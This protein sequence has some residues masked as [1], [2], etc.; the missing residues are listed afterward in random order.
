MNNNTRYTRRRFIVATSA[1]GLGLSIGV[2]PACSQ[3]KPSSTTVDS[4]E[5]KESVAPILSTAQHDTILDEVNAWVHI[6]SDDT[7][8]VRIARSEMGQGTITG[9][10][11]LVAEELECDW[12]KVSFEFPTPGQSVARERVWGDFSTG[13]SNGLRGSQQYMREGGAAARLMLLQAAANRWNVPVSECRARDSVIMHEPSGNKLRFGQ[14]AAEAA[15]LEPPAEVTLKDPTDW[16]TAGASKLRLDTRDKVTGKLKYAA[17]TQLPG[18]LY[19][20]IQDCPVLGGK[21]KSFD[22]SSVAD[23][24]G[25]RNVVEVKTESGTHGVA[26]IADTWWQAHSALQK[27]PVEWDYG[28]NRDF[29]DAK[30]QALL[31]SGLDAD[32]AFVGHAGGNIQTAFDDASQMVEAVYQY[33]A[34]NH[35]PMEPMNAT[36]RWTESHCEVWCP[37]QNGESA[38][39]AAA[40]AAGLPVEQCEVYKTIL[41]GGFGRRAMTDFVHQAVTVAKSMPDTPIK[42]QWSREEDQ[43]HGFYHPTTMAK[44]RGSLDDDGKL[45]GLH[46]RISGQSIL[47]GLMPA[48]LRDGMDVATFQGVAKPEGFGVDQAISYSFPNFLIDH[49]MRNPPIRPGFW[50]GVNINQNAVYMECFLEELAHAAKRDALEFRLEYMQDNPLGAKVLKAVA[51]E[52]GWGK[53]DGLSRGLAVLHAFGSHVAACAEVSTD[54]KGRVKI[55]RIVAATDCGTAVNPQQIEAQ[56]EGSFVFGLSAALFGKI[57]FDQGVVQ[58]TNFH[59][60]P[61][62]RIKD[63]PEVETLVMPSGGFFGGVG[64]PTIGV[65]APAVLNAIF[66]ATGKRVRRL[67]LSQSDVQLA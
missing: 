22:A 67:P 56:V 39:A 59:S 7:V 51:D 58:E 64:E 20:S 37:T 17:D 45:T 48:R 60:Y 1:T 15:Q 32:E 40:Q 43:L 11:Q 23:M 4:G 63:M 55:E 12:N 33:P 38:L 42:L 2:L 26:V 50:R 36:A 57:S 13:G 27:L 21:L 9:L 30:L 49:A 34:Q 14:L 25:V 62:M 24:P 54:D 41:G 53:D 28:E 8:T 61:S 5:I 46:M 44:L 65:A 16:H 10:A 66:N 35:A 52:S 29:N 19:A 47:A 6:A 18:M 31:E 3:E